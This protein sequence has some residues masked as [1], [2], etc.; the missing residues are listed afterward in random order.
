VDSFEFKAS[1][2]KASGPETEPEKKR[3]RHPPP[4]EKLDAKSSGRI[5]L[6]LAFASGAMFFFVGYLYF[7]M[8][9]NPTFTAATL[10]HS[11]GLGSEG[12]TIE[13]LDLYWKLCAPY[14]IGSFFLGA[15]LAISLRSARV[16]HLGWV[17]ASTMLTPAICLFPGMVLPLLREVLLF[18]PPVML[19]YAASNIVHPD[20]PYRKRLVYLDLST[21]LPMYLGETFLVAL[22]APGAVTMYFMMAVTGICAMGFILTARREHFRYLDER[23]PTPDEATTPGPSPPAQLPPEKRPPTPHP[24]KM[25]TRPAYI[26]LAASAALLVIFLPPL[27][28]LGTGTDLELYWQLRTGDS[29][30]KFEHATPDV[31]VRAMVINRGAKAAEGLVELVV[32]NDT[33]DFPVDSIQSIDGFGSWYVEYTIQIPNNTAARR[34]IT[35]SLLFNGEVLDTQLMK[36]PALDPLLALAAVMM[37]KAVLDRRRGR[38]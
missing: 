25:G 34:N 33:L 29:K 20:N 37:I 32:H 2:A 35:M 1:P 22:K 12:P 18:L 9:T 5:L 23:S 31:F 7:L 4:W 30:N 14:V 36:V 19:V 17:M 8:I 10:Y 15:W 27:S 26:L 16:K 21:V 24:A 6:V 28:V 11:G 38:H 13:G 3:D